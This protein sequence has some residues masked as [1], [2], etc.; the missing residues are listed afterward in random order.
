MRHTTS[1][2]TGNQELP[3]PCPLH[4]AVLCVGDR[5][6]TPWLKLLGKGAPDPPMLHVSLKRTGAVLKKAKAEVR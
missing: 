6:V 3:Q 5:M 2:R 4:V 1:Q